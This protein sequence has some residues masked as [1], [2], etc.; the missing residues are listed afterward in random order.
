MNTWDFSEGKREF[1]KISS[2]KDELFLILDFY[3]TRSEEA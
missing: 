3:C 2:D 1:L